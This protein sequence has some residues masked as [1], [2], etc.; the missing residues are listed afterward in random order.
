MNCGS[1]KKSTM[2]KSK[3]IIQVS[4]WK[5]LKTP[6]HEIGVEGMTVLEPEANGR[7]KATRVL[8]RTG[9]HG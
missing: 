8:S 6:L 5:R 7:Q 3:P 4:S 1:D 2:T 9:I